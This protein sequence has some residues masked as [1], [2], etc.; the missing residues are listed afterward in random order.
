MQRKSLYMWFENQDHGLVFLYLRCCW[1][2]GCREEV[3]NFFWIS[4]S[5]SLCCWLL[6]EQTMIGWK[7]FLWPSDW[8]VFVTFNE[9]IWNCKNVMS[10]TAFI[11]FLAIFTGKIKM[12]MRRCFKMISCWQ[13]FEFLSAF[14]SLPVYSGALK[15]FT[16]NH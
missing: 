16:A 8:Q 4:R 3:R 1:N 9:L 15:V 7:R 6:E 11:W 2:D 13:S 12:R 10:T 14:E 5:R